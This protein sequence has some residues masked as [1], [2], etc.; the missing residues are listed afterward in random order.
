MVSLLPGERDWTRYT[1]LRFKVRYPETGERNRNMFLFDGKAVHRPGIN[2]T[3]PGGRLDLFQESRRTFRL[4]LRALKKHNPDIDLSNI[5]AVQFFW[6][7]TPVVGETVFYF[8]DVQLLTAEDLEREKK[9]G[10]RRQFA[11]LRNMVP[12]AKIKK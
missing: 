9:D 10:Y 5:M 4:D 8:D 7:S 11:E 6:S 3:I 1:E 2:D 12:G